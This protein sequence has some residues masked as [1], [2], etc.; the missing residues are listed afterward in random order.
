[1][2]LYGG[3]RH[4]YF[5]VWGHGVEHLDR[6]LD[7]IRQHP[8]FQIAMILEHKP[9][10]V[11]ELVTAVYSFDYAPIEHL[12]GKTQYLRQTPCISY[13]IFVRNFAPDEDYFGEGGYRH[14]ESRTVKALKERIRD[15]LNP[16]IDGKRSE[17]HVIHASDN[18]LQT[19][20]ILR[21]LGFPGVE[22]LLGKNLV[23]NAPYHV[24]EIERYSIRK[25]AIEQIRC[26]ILTGDRYAYQTVFIPVEE[27]PH[28]RAICGDEDCYLRYLKTYR[29]TALTDNH[30]LQNLVELK[31]TFRY[32]EPPFDCDFVLVREEQDG[33][34]SV[35]DGVHRLALLKYQGATALQV[36]VV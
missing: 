9:R 27:T 8:A 1:M 16:R 33:M 4:D 10:S 2:N 12:R 11:D 26:S 6:M 5:L 29:G 30:M 32:L 34:F 7:M 21:Y 23:L 35:M 24:R 25:I 18:Q 15:C 14:I 17:E 22:W 31:K 13:F 19:D 3:C 28:Y 20:H 36:A